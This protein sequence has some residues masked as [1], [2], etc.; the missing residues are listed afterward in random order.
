M[1]RVWQLHEHINTIFTR[2]NEMPP[3][4]IH[5]CQVS[6]I[7]TLLAIQ[8]VENVEL[9]A[10]AG[11]LH[12]IA[13]LRKHDVEPYKIQGFTKANHGE[14]GA[15]IAMEILNEL[16]ITSQEENEIICNAVKN[17]YNNFTETDT[18]IDEIVKD[19]DVFAHWISSV[20]VLSENVR[21]NR[22]RWDRVCRELNI[23]N[24]Q[25]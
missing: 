21:G 1:S 15:E 6:Q 11:L 7:C 24:K 16:N 23:K 4:Y 13:T 2:I 9:A 18:P 5:I 17:H 20:S 14:L 10:M 25:E 19:A 8:R 3:V 22:N 12:D